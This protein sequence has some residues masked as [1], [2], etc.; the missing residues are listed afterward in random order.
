MPRSSYKVMSEENL[1]T[2]ATMLSACEQRAVKSER[3]FV[4]I[5]KARFMEKYIDEEFEGII[6]S[7]TKFGAFVLLRQ[8]EVDG[9]VRKESLAKEKLEFDEDT[10]TLFNSRTGLRFCIG[11]HV[12]IKVT[13]ADP[14]A[15]QVDFQFVEKLF[16]ALG[17]TSTNQ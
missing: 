16:N 13:N 12:K 14:E 10:L 5:K 3:Q 17:K 1:A 2:A 4:S 6:S 15:G 7:V 8:F 9:L 11:D